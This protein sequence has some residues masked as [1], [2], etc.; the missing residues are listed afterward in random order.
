MTKWTLRYNGK[1]AAD[2]AEYIGITVDEA[3]YIHNDIISK[4]STTH[5]LHAKPYLI[6]NI[7]E[8]NS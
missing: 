7:T 6:E 3:E 8:V 2:L 4:R 1:S 5:Y